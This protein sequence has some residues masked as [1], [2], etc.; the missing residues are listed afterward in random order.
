MDE[1]LNEQHEQEMPKKK[2]LDRKTCVRDIRRAYKNEWPG[3]WVGYALG[4]IITLGI[5]LLFFWWP[6]WFLHL[7]GVL[8]L[9][10]N[11]YLG[12]G[13]AF[14]HILHLCGVCNV[15]LDVMCGSEETEDEHG[16]KYYY[17]YFSHHGSKLVSKWMYENIMPGELMFISTVPGILRKPIGIYRTRE[18]EWVGDPKG[19]KDYTRLVPP[20]PEKEEVENT[21]L[22]RRPL[23]RGRKWR[24]TEEEV[25]RDLCENTF[26]TSQRLSGVTVG[27]LAVGALLVLV[28][29]MVALIAL[30]GG[31][32]LCAALWI[33]RG[34]WLRAV[35]AH[36]FVVKQDTLMDKDPIT[37]GIGNRK[38]TRYLL[39]FRNGTYTLPMQ[40]E[41]VYRDAELGDIFLVV[42]LEGKNKRIRAVYNTLDVEW[43]GADFTEEF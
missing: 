32:L 8:W 43:D 25:A 6:Y 14:R 42:R 15:A 21:I 13:E 7:L 18:Y 4:T 2:P 19:Y 28:D 37:R 20:Q 41:S 38:N 12:M 17:F 1:N 9:V 33:E 27:V 36:R 24:L 40:D 3:V 35:R 10:M 26:W 23:T 34:V 29:A 31:S 39:S 16:H 11:W 30:A 5:A 22:A